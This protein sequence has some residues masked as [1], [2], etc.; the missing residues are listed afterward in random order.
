MKFF[1]RNLQHRAR[2]RPPRPPEVKTQA[3]EP[4]GKPLTGSRRPA[5][6]LAALSSVSAQ[7]PVRFPPPPCQQG[8]DAPLADRRLVYQQALR[9]PTVSASEWSNH[10]PSRWRAS[11]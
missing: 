1:T 5:S 4:V 6:L 3:L 8:A 10:S 9:R 7:K 2:R 11:A